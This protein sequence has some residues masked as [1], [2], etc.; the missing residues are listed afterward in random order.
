MVLVVDCS[1]KPDL[2]KV[3][4]ELKS[5]LLNTDLLEAPLLILAN[6]QDV[7]GCLTPAEL[8]QELDL[9]AAEIRRPYFV[10][11][12]CALTGDGL[13]TGFDWLVNAIISSVPKR[14]SH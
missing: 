11:G 5:L 2:P 9:N 12:C 10:Q 4:Y 14:Q 3:K 1:N 13:D 6:K 8:A 7:K